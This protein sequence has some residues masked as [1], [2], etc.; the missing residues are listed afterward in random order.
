MN[1][2]HAMNYCVTVLLVLVGMLSSRAQSIAG[3]LSL[4]SNQTIKLEGFS[5]LK[6]YPISSSTIDKDGEL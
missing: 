5:G 6:T 4:M 2:N 3:N 1:K